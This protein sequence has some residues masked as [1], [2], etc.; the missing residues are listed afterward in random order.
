MWT[1]VFRL[2]F[3][4]RTGYWQ[5]QV[6]LSN[7]GKIADIV[8]NSLSPSTSTIYY[9][10][11]TWVIAQLHS[12]FKSFFTLKATKSHYCP[13]TTV[14]QSKKNVIMP[15]CN[16]GTVECRYNAVHYNMILHA[17][18]QWLRQNIHQRFTSKRHPISHPLVSFVRILEKFDRVITALVPK[19]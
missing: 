16:H 2:T 6:K 9:C 13:S 7:T 3:V 19:C 8:K 12:S 1:F 14:Q 10:D 11:V 17:S 18:L 5:T 15:W 4:L